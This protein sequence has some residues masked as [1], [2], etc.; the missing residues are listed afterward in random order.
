MMQDDDTDHHKSE[1]ISVDTGE[2]T[3]LSDIEEDNFDHQEEVL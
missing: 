3:G 1:H 2:F